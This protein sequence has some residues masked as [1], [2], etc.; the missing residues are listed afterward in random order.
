M[1]IIVCVKQTL[2]T[3]ATI[4]IK[5]G[6]IHAPNAARI[7]NPYDE[8]A[9]EEAVRI[10]ERKPD[11]E[12]TL[13]TLGGENARDILKTGLA[14]GADRAIYINENKLDDSDGLA[15]ASKLAEVIKRSEFDLILCGRQ[16]V[17]QDRAQVGPA[18][19]VFLGIPVI[20]VATQLDFSDDFQRVVATRQIEGGS[21]RIES[22]LPL[23]VTCQKG[24]N[25]PR[26]PS[27]K[28]IMA[29]RKKEVVEIAGSELTTVASDSNNSATLRIIELSL[30]PKRKS[31]IM[32]EGSAP[33]MASE[34]A[35]VLREVEKVI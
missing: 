33:A 26:L 4:E 28:G 30:P 11:T 21:E 32:L 27:L 9:V 35:K 8:F 22:P 2:D 5:Q 1:K 12:I 19:S 15:I 13:I 3:N 25:S 29:A 7:M 10:K 23:L 6:A 20:S 18:L 31:A 24:L 17:D 16:A 14:M 34:L